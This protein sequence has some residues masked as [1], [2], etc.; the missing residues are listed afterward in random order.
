MPL[1]FEKPVKPPKK[2]PTRLRRTRLTSRRSPSPRRQKRLS[3]M[4]G[5]PR[6]KMMRACDALQSAIVLARGRCEHVERR[7]YIGLEGLEVEVL[8]RCTNPATDAA[9]VYGKKARPGLRYH[10]VNLL[11]LCRAHHDLVGSC[12]ADPSKPSKM[13]DLFEALFS[14][15]DFQELAIQA[16]YTRKLDLK[17]VHQG[18]LTVSR[19]MGLR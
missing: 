18:L 3:A 13:R 12:T 14:P 16:R 19:N 1:A 11:A 2:P 9:H 10:P 8:D 7:Q 17:I 4:S 5:R 15:E 6:A